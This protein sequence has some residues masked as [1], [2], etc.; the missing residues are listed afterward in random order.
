[1]QAAPALLDMALELT[2]L[3]RRATTALV[4]LW[5]P[6]TANGSPVAAGGGASVAST[7]THV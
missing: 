6:E 5:P 2:D 1:M 4:P 7:A 3:G